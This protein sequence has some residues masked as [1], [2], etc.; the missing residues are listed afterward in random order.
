M[1]IE[2][3]LFI[4]KFNNMQFK[5]L[6]SIAL[7]FNMAFLKAQSI[8]N[9][10]I[11]FI[12]N[13]PE[14]SSIVFTRNDTTMA[15]VRSDMKFPLASTVKIIIAI[16]YAQQAANGTI[17]PEEEI[18]VADID[19]FYVLNT[20]GNAHP[21]WKAEMQEKNLIQNGKVRLKYIAK[22]MIRYSSNANTEY[23]MDKLGFENINANLKNLDL[24]NHDKLY[25]FISALFLTSNSRKVEDKKFFNDLTN[26]PKEEYTKKCF[27]IHEKLKTD[28]NENMKAKFV[29]PNMALQHIWS[30]RL[31]ASTTKE[32]VSIIQKINSHTYFDKKVHEHLDPIME[33]PLEYNPQNAKS[34]EHLGQKGG[35]TAFILTQASYATLKNGKRIESAIFFNNLKESEF[36]KLQ[37]AMNEFNILCISSKTCYEVAKMLK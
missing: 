37:S 9:Y 26:M 4:L 29:F 14:R 27:E 34:F 24:P 35:S 20:D 2:L 30:D 23:L 6:I 22:G 21:E 32:Y 15:D 16:E 19:R 12:K 28:M 31:P 13:N 25:P 8:N 33:W 11:D 36:S 10:V 7:V 1:N 3:Q 18:S 17:D 5:T